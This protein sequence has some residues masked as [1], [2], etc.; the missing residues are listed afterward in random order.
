MNLVDD[1]MLCRMLLMVDVVYVL[2]HY[3]MNQDRRRHPQHLLQRHLRYDHYRISRLK[4]CWMPPHF[5]LLRFYSWD[6]VSDVDLLND[7]C[8]HAVVS[9]FLNVRGDVMATQ[10]QPYRSCAQFAYNVIDRN[11]KSALS[12]WITCRNLSG[13]YC[14]NMIG[15]HRMNINFT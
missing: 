10:L 2:F 9:P 14:G 7:S 8:Q 15:E 12:E 3:L 5:N 11:S 13:T 1:N 6:M 4:T